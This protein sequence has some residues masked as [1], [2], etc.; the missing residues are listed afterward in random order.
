MNIR[1]WA[2]IWSFPQKTFLRYCY[3]SCC[4]SIFFSC[5][6]FAV[7]SMTSWIKCLMCTSICSWLRQWIFLWIYILAM[8]SRFW[9]IVIYVLQYI[10]MCVLIS[11]WTKE[12]LMGGFQ[13]LLFV[14]NPMQFNIHIYLLNYVLKIRSVFGICF[15]FSYFFFLGNHEIPFIRWLTNHTHKCFHILRCQAPLLILLYSIEPQFPDLSVVVHMLF[16]KDSDKFVYVSYY[17]GN[18]ISFTLYFLQGLR[19]F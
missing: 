16:F 13:M 9:Y 17:H 15:K 2:L 5:L 10:V 19:S 6:N 12:V 3:C 7:L 18:P 1:L 14:F 4:L 11:S 8:S